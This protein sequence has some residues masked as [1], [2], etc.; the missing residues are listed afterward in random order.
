M[1]DDD[2]KVSARYRELAREEPPRHVDDA[3]L[4]AAR[5]H[6]LASSS[7]SHPAEGGA[8]TFPWRLPRSSFWQSR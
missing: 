8:G 6:R 7:A 4:A 5:R 2:A 3:I 1:T